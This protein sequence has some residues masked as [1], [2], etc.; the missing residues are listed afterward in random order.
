[1]GERIRLVGDDEVKRQAGNKVPRLS[2]V[3]VY[4]TLQVG[5]KEIN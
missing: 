3:Y 1:M 4:A 5:I 2:D